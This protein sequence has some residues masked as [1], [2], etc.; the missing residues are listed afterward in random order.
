MTFS[1]FAQGNESQQR[2]YVYA[3]SSY[4]DFYFIQFF[5]LLN[6]NALWFLWLF[7]QIVFRLLEILTLVGISKED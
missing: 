1:L 5:L 3:P 2:N 6:A 7:R 4:T